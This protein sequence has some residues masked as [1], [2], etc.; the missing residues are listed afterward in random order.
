MM[1][2]KLWVFAGG[3]PQE[4]FGET[5]GPSHVNFFGIV[6]LAEKAGLVICNAMAPPFS[7]EK[8]FPGD[9]AELQSKKPVKTANFL[10]TPPSSVISY[11]SRSAAA[12]KFGGFGMATFP[13]TRELLGV[14]GRG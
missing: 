13:L 7:C 2:V 3:S 14:L 10:R 6:S 12:E 9:N 1:R 11:S 5:S 8:S 4:S